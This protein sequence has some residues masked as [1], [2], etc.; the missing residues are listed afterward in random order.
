MMKVLRTLAL[1]LLSLFCLLRVLV[2]TLV[3]LLEDELYSSE[4]SFGLIKSELLGF[5][6][7]TPFPLP[8]LAC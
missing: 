6:C 5:I 4:S 2:E 3:S 1:T 7:F 8:I